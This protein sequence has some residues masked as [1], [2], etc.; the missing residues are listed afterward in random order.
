MSKKLINSDAPNKTKPKVNKAKKSIDTL[1]AVI[2][3]KSTDIEIVNRVLNG[4]SELRASSDP[5]S[6]YVK[7]ISRY[8]LLTPEE[9]EALIK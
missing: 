7:E 3:K 9:E 4:D 6:Q 5:L 1:P 8:K 2:N